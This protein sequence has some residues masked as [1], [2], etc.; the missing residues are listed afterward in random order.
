MK[1][2]R[3]LQHR[4]TRL[5]YAG[6]GAWVPDPNAAMDF[7]SA[8]R[9]LDAA[10]ELEFEAL[11]LVLKFPNS[12]MDVACALSSLK[13]PGAGRDCGPTVPGM[14]ML[15]LPVLTEWAKLAACSL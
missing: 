8:I 13:P 11:Q 10:K 3:L 12:E 5:Y 9:A 1:F 15:F 4:D 7:P 6:K 2:S 14:I